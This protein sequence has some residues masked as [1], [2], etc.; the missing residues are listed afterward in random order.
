MSIEFE[1]INNMSMYDN[2]QVLK[3]FNEIIRHK[4]FK[5]KIEEILDETADWS[6]K[7]VLDADQNSWNQFNKAQVYAHANSSQ[8]VEAINAVISIPEYVSLRLDLNRLVT[9]SLKSSELLPSE[10]EAYDDKFFETFESYL[11][12]ITEIFDPQ[13][14][15]LRELRKEIKEQKD[16]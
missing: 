13:Q 7:N 14:S 6:D 5:N 10:F 16:S 1:G 4:D 9:Y 11:R 2:V 15:H 12:Y 8:I 3:S